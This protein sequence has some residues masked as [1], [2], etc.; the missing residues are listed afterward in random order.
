MAVPWAEVF[1][2]GKRV[3]V[4]PIEGLKLDASRHRV[5]LQGPSG[6]V[7]REVT[8]V[9]GKNFTLREAMP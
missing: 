7:N 5:R 8:I 3:G 6:A 1:V 9:A 2:D 4:T